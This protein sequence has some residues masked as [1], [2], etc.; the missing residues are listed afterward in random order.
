MKC[1]TRPLGARAE[2]DRKLLEGQRGLH[3][4]AGRSATSGEGRGSAEE[5]DVDGHERPIR[6]IQQVPTSGQKECSPFSQV[7]AVA[8]ADSPRLSPQPHAP[9]V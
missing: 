5:V 3:R 2:E 4:H 6:S 9:C 1:E 7:G 8:A